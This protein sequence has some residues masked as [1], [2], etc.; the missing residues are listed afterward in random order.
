MPLFIL[1]T[2]L[3]KP[4]ANFTSKQLPLFAVSRQASQRR[5]LTPR[6]FDAYHSSE[7]GVGLLNAGYSNSARAYCYIVMQPCLSAWSGPTLR[8]LTTLL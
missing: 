7:L 6:I 3:S 2:S 4:V 5:V 1:A 8:R